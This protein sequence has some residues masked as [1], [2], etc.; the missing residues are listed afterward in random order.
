[1]KITIAIVTLGLLGNV[2]PSAFGQ[3][4]MLLS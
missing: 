2:M 3:A 1:M 4:G